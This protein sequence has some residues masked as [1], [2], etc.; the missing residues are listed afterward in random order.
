V[1]SRSI[2]AWPAG[3]V[4]PT[5]GIRLAIGEI[6]RTPVRNDAAKVTSAKITQS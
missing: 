2:S 5:T 3:V 6:T 4:G 1:N